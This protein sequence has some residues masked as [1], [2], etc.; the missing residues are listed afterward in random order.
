[1]TADEENEAVTAS[2]DTLVKRL[3]TGGKQVEAVVT[4]VLYRGDE[5]PRI[6]TVL[7]TDPT[8]EET[9]EDRAQARANVMLAASD[10]LD[11]H[12]HE[13]GLCTSCNREKGTIQ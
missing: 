1:V 4:V 10:L 2:A 12:V 8:P 7:T 11:N 5:D 9:E 6:G 13:R 3:A